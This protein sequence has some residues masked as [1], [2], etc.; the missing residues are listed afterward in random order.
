MINP[1]PIAPSKAT[2]HIVPFVGWYRILPRQRVDLPT[3]P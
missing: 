2:P 3:P 1:L